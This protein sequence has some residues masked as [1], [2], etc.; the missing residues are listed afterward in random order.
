M[1]RHHQRLEGAAGSAPGR[2]GRFRHPL[3]APGPRRHPARPPRPGHRDHRPARRPGQVQLGR[4]AAAAGGGVCRHLHQRGALSRPNLGGRHAA[5]GDG[6]SGRDVLRHDRPDQQPASPGDP[7]LCAVDRR[8]GR[9]R[10]ASGGFRGAA[11]QTPG[12]A[13]PL[14]RRRRTAAGGGARSH[15]GGRDRRGHAGHAAAHLDRAGPDQGCARV[16]ARLRR[17][18]LARAPHPP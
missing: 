7:D 17:R 12:A 3:P 4:H 10:L 16:R 8:G 9:I 18:V 14:D 1:V 6:G 13:S 15:R 11:I 2:G 5:A